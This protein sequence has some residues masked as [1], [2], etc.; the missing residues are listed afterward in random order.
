L[1]FTFLALKVIVA[2]KGD[3]PT[4]LGIFQTTNPAVTVIGALLSGLP[5]GAVATVV[6]I[7]YLA[8]KGAS[9]QCCTLA[10]AAALAC[11][12]CQVLLAG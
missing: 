2:A 3:I 8:A 4:A 6:I 1:L 7:S 9:L 11:C 12:C 5:L 10:A